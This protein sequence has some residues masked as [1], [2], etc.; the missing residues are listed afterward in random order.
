MLLFIHGYLFFYFCDLAKIRIF[1]KNPG[2]FGD[3]LELI[4]LIW[5]FQPIV[6]GDLILDYF[7]LLYLK[8]FSLP[9]YFIFSY[10]IYGYFI[11]SYY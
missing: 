8:L 3:L 1:F 5:Q 10:F 9:A 11:L 4:V 2:I 6:L 7:K